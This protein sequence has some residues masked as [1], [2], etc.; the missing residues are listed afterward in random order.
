MLLS[1][2]NVERTVDLSK[3]ITLFN[4]WKEKSRCWLQYVKILDVEFKEQYEQDIYIDNNV[5][6]F[7][8][9]DLLQWNLNCANIL[10]KFI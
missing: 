7:F 3:T 4:I 10:L 2:R 8:N 6:E 1:R 9:L 5:S